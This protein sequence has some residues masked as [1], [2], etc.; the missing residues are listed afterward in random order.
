MREGRRFSADIRKG[1]ADEQRRAYRGKLSEIDTTA[2]RAKA[3]C[4]QEYDQIRA[5]LGQTVYAERLRAEKAAREQKAAKQAEA[6]ARRDLAAKSAQKARECKAERQKLAEEKTTAKR[7]R[8]E[9]RKL[10]RQA[11]AR[12]KVQPKASRREKTSEKRD[13]VEADL[14]PHLVPLW[15][16]E[17][18]RFKAPPAVAAGRM[19]L[20][21]AFEHH[22][23]ENPAAG[24]EAQEAEAE[25]F[26][27][28]LQRQE[29]AQQREHDKAPRSSTGP[30]KTRP[31]ASKGVG[32]EAW[33][34]R[35][36]AGS[37]V[38]F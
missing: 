25:S 14:P 7:D 36:A 23:S 32:A 9:I 31:A 29:R 11:K 21:E 20:A 3:E 4:R 2:T 33:A 37:A 19:S 38:P 24:L 28:D 12:E 15:R 10:E 35:F 1:I 27:R 16:R 18:K 5:G 22:A 26:V 8:A 30:R 6:I 34:K 13:A 17:G